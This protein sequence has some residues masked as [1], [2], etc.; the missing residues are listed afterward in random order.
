VLPG[1]EKGRDEMAEVF[2]F[3]CTWTSFCG[4]DSV[5]ISLHCYVR[6]GR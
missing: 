6:V 5:R 1:R 3:G 4:C 2:N